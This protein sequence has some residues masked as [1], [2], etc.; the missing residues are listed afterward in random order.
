MKQPVFSSS[1]RWF[2]NPQTTG[3]TINNE[4]TT[5]RSHRRGGLILSYTNL[6]PKKAYNSQTDWAVKKKPSWATVCPGKD[7]HQIL[8][9]RWKLKTW[10]RT[11]YLKIKNKYFIMHWFNFHRSFFHLLLNEI[12]TPYLL[13]F[14]VGPYTASFQYWIMDIFYYNQ[15]P[16]QCKIE[17]YDY[18]KKII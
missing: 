10:F 3:A 8:T 13:R 6:R 7:R 9:K 16:D 11:I 15:Q 18:Q 1:A 5:G 2:K 17:C 4:S 14:S 12:T